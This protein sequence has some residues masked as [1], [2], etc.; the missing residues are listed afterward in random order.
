MRIVKEDVNG[1]EPPSNSLRLEPMSDQRCDEGPVLGDSVVTAD[2]LSHGDIV[3][4]VRVAPDRVVA[5]LVTHDLL[6]TYGG[7]IFAVVVRDSFGRVN[8]TQISHGD[9]E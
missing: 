8:F 2:D 3:Y 6:A 7:P 5:R 9:V 4:F 1:L